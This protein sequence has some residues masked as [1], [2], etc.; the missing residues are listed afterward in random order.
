MIGPE[1]FAQQASSFF[2][3]RVAGI[4]RQYQEALLRNNAVD[5][6]DLL[7]RTVLLFQQHDEILAN[8]ASRFQYIMIDEYQDTNRPQYLLAKLL[9]ASHHNLCVV[10]DDD[11]SIYAWRGAEG[12][13]A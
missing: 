7:M 6:D 1:S 10:G 11:Q 13:G 4:Y 12:S 3:Q 9:A 5:F 8:Y 2:D